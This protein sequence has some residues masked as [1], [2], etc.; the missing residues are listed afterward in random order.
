MKFAKIRL[1]S[2]AYKSRWIVAASNCRGGSQ[3]SQRECHMSQDN[4]E[5]RAS[6][7]SR[8]K[9]LGAAAAL[10]A[11]SLAMPAFVQPRIERTSTPKVK[12]FELEE[13]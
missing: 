10:G 9:F 13:L 4:H 3:I 8:R 2:Q 6:E 5:R 7:L 1:Q 11:T 12:P